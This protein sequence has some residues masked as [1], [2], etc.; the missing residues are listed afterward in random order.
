MLAAD[1]D[2][3][4]EGESSGG[5]RPMVGEVGG[6]MKTTGS[7]E[8]DRT[9]VDWPRAGEVGRTLVRFEGRIPGE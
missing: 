2:D 4:L 1:R 7:V 9:M 5:G 8:S 3:L 6:E